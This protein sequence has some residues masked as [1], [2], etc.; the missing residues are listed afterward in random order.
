[1]PTYAKIAGVEVNEFNDLLQ[2]DANEAF[3]VFLKGLEG[4]SEGLI[5]MSHKLDELGIDGAR[6]VQVLAALASNT[7]LVRKH[8]TILPE[9]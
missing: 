3:L 9:H 6:S 8:Q 1:M 5:T 2:T 7:D 4:N